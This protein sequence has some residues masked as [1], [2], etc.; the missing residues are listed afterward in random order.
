MGLVIGQQKEMKSGAVQ[1]R[2]VPDILTDV[3]KAV[4]KDENSQS[5]KD[6]Q[7]GLQILSHLNA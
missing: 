7:I 3:M 1:K 6:K 2:N 5:K 4:N